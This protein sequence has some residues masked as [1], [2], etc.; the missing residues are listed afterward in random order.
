MTDRFHSRSTLRT[1]ISRGCSTNR[2]TIAD[3]PLTNS[4]PTRTVSGAEYEAVRALLLRAPTL[5]PH[6]RYDLARQIGTHIAA[7]MRHTPPDWA[8]PELFLACVAARFQQRSGMPQPAAYPQAYPQWG[9][10]PATPA[11]AAAAPPQTGGG[12]A[13]PA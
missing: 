13:P 3:T 4:T 10:P 8:H 12:F 6:I 7:R 5:P 2:K 1:T 9:A 11:V